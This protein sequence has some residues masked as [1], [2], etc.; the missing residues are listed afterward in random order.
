MKEKRYSLPKGWE[1]CKIKDLCTII[2][3]VSYPKEQ[4]RKQQAKDYYP[5]LRAGNIQ[6]TLVFSD[7]VFVPLQYIKTV[8][9]IRKYDIVIAM[10]S[11]SK[12][13]VGKAAQATN[14]YE[15][16]F[17]AFCG[18]LRLKEE[19]I[20]PMYF[21]YYFRTKDYRTR[22]SSLSAGVN[23][24]NL[25]KS[26]IENLDI[27]IAPLNEQK[28]IVQKTENLF[29]RFNKTNEELAKILPLL[30]KFRQ[31]VLAKAFSGELTQEWREQ[32]KDLEPAFKLLVRIREE[33][34]K[35][36]GKKYKEP[37]P[38]DTS[39][40]PDLP[41]GWEWATLDTIIES[42]QPGFACGKKDVPNG[43]FHLR[44]NNIDS[45]CNLNLDLVRTVPK[46]FREEKYLLRKGDVLF[47]HT[48]SQKLIGKTALF[49]MDGEFVFSNHLTR[50]RFFSNTIKSEW[51]WYYLSTLW[52]QGY[53]EN[54]C[55]QWVNQATIRK[56]TLLEV[57]IPIPPLLEQAYFIN[58]M[59]E[60]ST[61]ADM[62]EKSVKAV[63]D[64][65]DK[66]TQSILTKAFKGELVPQDP[67]DELASML[68]DK[69]KAVK[70]QSKI[71]RKRQGRRKQ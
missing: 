49:D 13:I 1:R 31:S 63:Q 4:V 40:L 69:I 65:C 53:F 41:E 21:G 6:D 10:S 23:I 52:R 54:K 67:N 56:E 19:S 34:K 60:M 29:T 2:R 20:N 61:H 50:I 62:V 55:K 12:N 38:I 68:L 47:C 17:G 28:R 32:R 11:G 22:I 7:L 70:K 42:A 44:M 18:L 5:V 24:N 59:K 46:S 9:F 14:D 33:R 66:L 43:L 16:G 35:K 39:D 26:Y 37:K 36:L 45:E 71:K 25:R 30:K 57:T 3:G 48:N 58:R 64:R 51:I 15:G 27:S 8:Q